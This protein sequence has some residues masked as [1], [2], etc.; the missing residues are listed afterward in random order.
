[1]M[2]TPSPFSL[3]WLL[4]LCSTNL[5]VGCRGRTGCQPVIEKM[6]QGWDGSSASEDP[7]QKQV[8]FVWGVRV[9]RVGRGEPLLPRVGIYRGWHRFPI[10]TWVAVDVTE[11]VDSGHSEGEQGLFFIPGNPYICQARE[12]A[13]CGKLSGCFSVTSVDVF[14]EKSTQN[15]EGNW[16]PRVRLSSLDSH[17]CPGVGDK[18]WKTKSWPPFSCFLPLEDQVGPQWSIRA[19]PSTAELDGLRE[20]LNL[21]F[22]SGLQ[23]GSVGYLWLGVFQGWNYQKVL[24]VHRI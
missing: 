16:K 18:T 5:N 24:V 11:C 23:F 17:L 3:S 14:I 15:R 22:C 8:Y 12:K 19:H 7:L 4:P 21:L 2:W 9:S 1:M 10:Y 6:E 13:M 20:W